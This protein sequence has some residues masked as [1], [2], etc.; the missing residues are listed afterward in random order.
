MFNNILKHSFVLFFTALTAIIFTSCNIKGIVGSGI[1]TTETRPITEFSRID[2]EGSYDVIIKQG[3]S[4]K[5][6]LKMDDNLLDN[7]ITEIN[8]DKLYIR[9]TSNVL[10]SKKSEIYI[11][12]KDIDRVAM[13]GA[14]NLT[15]ANAFNLNKLSVISSGACDIDLNLYSNALRLNLTGSNNV[16]V[17]GSSHSMDI[18]ISGYGDLNTLDY[19]CENVYLDI[20][21]AVFSKVYAKDYLDVNI[22]GAGEVSYKGNPELVKESSG[23]TRISSI[24]S[25]ANN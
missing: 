14:V 3:N 23:I 24:K 11:T 15:T 8:G 25:V 12:V 4:Y 21:G 6:F 1:V 20:S 9:S 7:T 18:V 16:E 17:K 13:R 5:L 22:S 2:I 19:L 10:D